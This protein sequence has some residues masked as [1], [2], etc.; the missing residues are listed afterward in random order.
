MCK[1]Q[2]DIGVKILHSDRGGE[3]TSTEF[4]S[5]LKS[6]ETKQKLTIHDTSQH[7]GI[8]ECRNRTI[9]ECVRALLHA[10]RLPKLLWAH[11]VSH[12][13]WLMNQTS[14]KAIEGTTPFELVYGKKPDFRVLRE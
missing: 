5:Y 14:S 6:Q 11:A 7:N 1:T 2:H 12:V 8:A 4:Q 10:S 9:V 3:Y 13:V